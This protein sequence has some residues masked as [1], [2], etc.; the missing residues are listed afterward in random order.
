MRPS[1]RTWLAA[2]VVGGVFAL[3]GCLAPTLPVP[4]PE[5]FDVSAPD[6]DGIVTVKGG[7]G[8]AR[9]NWTV[10]VEKQGNPPGVNGFEDTALPDGSWEIKLPAKSGDVLSIWQEQG[11]E[12]STV[13]P[14]KVVP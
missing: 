14:D 1:R 13:S 12:R 5:N 4:P 8:S 7:K 3:A 11:T 10:H 6:A 9:P 2:V